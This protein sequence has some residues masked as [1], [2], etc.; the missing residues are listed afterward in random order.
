MSAGRVILLHGTSSSGKT[1]VARAVQRR[2]DEP[3]LRLGIDVFWSAV[4]ERWFEHGER[5]AEGFLWTETSR[6]VPGPVGQRIAGAMRAAVGAVARSGVDVIADDVFIDPSWAD[7]WREEL[8]GIETLWV[9][10]VAPLAV[11]EER[12]RARGN[13]I[14]GEAR[15]QIDDLHRGIDYDLVVDTSSVDPD[16]CA[17]SILAALR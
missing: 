6:I 17:A 4:H 10:V 12:E 2:S 15:A 7:A 16:A 13:R 14:L 11:L 1:T 3:W 8:A 9:G 5:A